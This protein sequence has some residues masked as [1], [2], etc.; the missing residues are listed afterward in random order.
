[1]FNSTRDLL[2]RWSTTCWFHGIPF[3]GQN[4]LR[5]VC[6]TDFRTLLSDADIYS[7]EGRNRPRGPNSELALRPSR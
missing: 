6:Y 7:P 1:M 5:S 4:P 2:P 3:R